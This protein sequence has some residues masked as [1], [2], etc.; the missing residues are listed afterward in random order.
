[1][2]ALN[3]L[4]MSMHA[5]ALQIRYNEYS[6]VHKASSMKMLTL[7][8]L[9]WKN[10]SILHNTLIDSNTFWDEQEWKHYTKPH[11][12]ANAQPVW[13]STKLQSHTPKSSVETSW[14]N[15]VIITAKET[16]FEWDVQQ[17][18]LSMM[19]RRL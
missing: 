13:R 2:E 11:L 4:Q 9:V 19:V 14:W 18:L 16:K 7:M 15:E 3:C 8:N 12:C 5:V 6:T 10:S 17:A 1:M